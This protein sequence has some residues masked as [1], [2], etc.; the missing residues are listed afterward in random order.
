MNREE[1]VRLVEE[2]LARFRGET[3]AE[4]VTR[5]DRDRLAEEITRDNMWYQLKLLCVWD[6]NPRRRRAG[7]R[8]Y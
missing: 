3:Y 7:D 5:I 1:A 2:W 4:L 8:F 6:S